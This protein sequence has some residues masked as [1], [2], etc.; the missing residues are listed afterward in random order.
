MK[1]INCTFNLIV[2]QKLQVFARE[3]GITIRAAIRMIINDFLK[4][5]PLY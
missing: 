2:Y 4:D 5:K 1:R 3:K